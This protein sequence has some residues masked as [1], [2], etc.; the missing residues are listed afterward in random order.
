MEARGLRLGCR[1]VSR[2][3][4][5]RR[6]TQNHPRRQTRAPSVRRGIGAAVGDGRVPVTDGRIGRRWRTNAGGM[7]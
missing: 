5:L 6:R 1:A 2:Y 3:Q 7:P 4:S